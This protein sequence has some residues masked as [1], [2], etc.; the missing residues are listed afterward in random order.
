MMKV[1]VTM[2]REN[3]TKIVELPDNSRV[4]ELVK[5]L[6]Y[7]IQGVVVLRNNLPIVEDEKLNDGDK[8]TVILTASGG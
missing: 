3:V 7:T 8:L 1:E 4:K 5:R 6:G 2:V